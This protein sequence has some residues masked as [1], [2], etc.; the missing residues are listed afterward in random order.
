MIVAEN[1]AKEFKVH[2]RKPGLLGSLSTLFSREYR[3]VRAVSGVSFE[4]PA[5]VKAAYVGANGAGK[6]TTVKMLTGIM[7][8]TSGRAV[9]AGLEPYRE[10]RRNSANIGVVFGQRSQLWWDLPV[11]DSFRIL[12]R[13]HEIP[14]AVYRRNMDLYRDLLDL[15]ALGNTPV[16]QLSLGQRMRA[17]VAASLL[18][19][20]KVVFLDE[21]TIG[22]DL[23]LKE[24][25]RELVNRVN[26]ELGTTV[27]LTSHDMGDISAICDQVLVVN[28]GEVVHRGT[29]HELLRTADTR[30]VFFEHRQQ[31]E[32]QVGHGSTDRATALIEAHLDGASA[33]LVDGGRI[34]VEYP[35]DRWS[36]RQVMGFLLEHFDVTDC[37]APEPDLEMVLRRI[38]TGS[39]NGPSAGMRETAA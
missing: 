28:R 18:H 27:M 4:I 19:D 23:V 9:V 8:P 2:E 17:E 1:L 3:L 36:A 12:R 33:T 21:P 15:G 14:D 29:M 30:A 39:G 20:P 6:S 11:P 34:K 16:R 32:H 37:V 5:G 10:R 31:P 25:V 22:L 7:S 38:Y 35:A 24:A 13:I 26:A